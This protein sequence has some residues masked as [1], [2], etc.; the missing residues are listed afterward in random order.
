MQQNH[1]DSIAGDRSRTMPLGRT[2][3]YCILIPTLNEAENVDPLLEQVT[4]QVKRIG[5]PAEILVVDGGSKDDTC[6]R[7]EKWA[8]SC[9]QGLVRLVHSDARKGLSGDIMRGAAATQAEIVLVM[10]ADLSHPPSAIE[11]LVRPLIDDTHDLAIGSRYIPGGGTPGWPWYRLL[12]SRVAALL[13]WPLVN[14]QD[15]MSGYFCVRRQELLNLG[16]EASGFKIGLEVMVRGLDR[17]RTIEVPIVFKDRERGQSK[18]GMGVISTYLKQ[19]IALSGGSVSTGHAAKFSAV[20]AMGFLVDL[21]IF[22]VLWMLGAS[23]VLTHSISFLCATVFNFSLNSRWS[24]A[25]TAQ[26]DNSPSWTR[27]LRLLVV[28]I[29]ALA[30]R[31]AVLS[32]LVQDM[33]WYPHLA[34][35]VAVATTILVNFFGSAFFVFPKPENGRASAVRW[36][37]LATATVTYVLLLR[38]AFLGIIELMPQESYY[39][40]Y[41]QN[42]DI[43]YLD[44]P[45]MVAWLIALST[46]LLGDGEATVR[47]PSIVCWL[48]SAGF[49]YQLAKNMFGK[50]QAILSVMLLSML[51]IYVFVGFMMTPDAPL[52]AAWA[53]SLYFLERALLAKRRIAWYGMGICVGLG[54]LSKYTIALLGPATLVFILIHR[55]SRR[56]LLSF[57][58]YLAAAMAAVLFSPVI[59]WNAQHDWASFQFQGSRRW[60]GQTDF[61]LPDML[62]AVLLLLTPLG[63]LSVCSSLRSLKR[64]ESNP[65]ENSKIDPRLLFAR[66]F[67]ILPF[68]VFVLQSLRHDSQLNWT[69]PIWLAVVPMLAHNMA[70]GFNTVQH[71][72]NRMIDSLWKASCA[73]LLLF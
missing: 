24:F 18:L 22:S 16:R 8:K 50:T 47:L 59:I 46:R 5:L 35:V 12:T 52:Y 67:V 33:H 13:A 27:Y 32:S 25:E 69:G 51:P 41:A 53:G 31:G 37:V 48:I 34:L 3:A 28:C 15:P 62:F 73:A 38:I 57:H 61:S 64:S 19:L 42:L 30:L 4:A 70:S 39:W 71:W 68:G 6:Q 44:H 72:I 36:R 10:D 60:S 56:W 45:P 55:D 54:M 1:I 20:G 11:P 29:L 7:V 14:V 17:L 65:I 58:P 49:I 40:V 26:R 2:P 66:V 43:G 23:L 21:T 63:I 9:H